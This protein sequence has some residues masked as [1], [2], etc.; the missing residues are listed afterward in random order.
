MLTK[1]TDEIFALLKS[2][3]SYA[4]VGRHF[5]VSRQRI[6]QIKQKYFPNLQK[7]EY[8]KAILKQKKLL[9]KQ[10]NWGRNS[11]ELSDEERAK[12]LRFQRK[13]Q[14]VKSTGLS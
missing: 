14:N 2:G 9:E 13:R 12:H 4:D 6:E 1:K 11:W 10:K 5:G 3:M 7:N 8:G